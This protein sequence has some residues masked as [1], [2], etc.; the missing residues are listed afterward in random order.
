MSH[1]L[2]VKLISFRKTVIGKYETYIEARN[3]I[4]LAVAAHR[5]TYGD[6][7]SVGRS[8]NSASKYPYKIEITEMTSEAGLI[9]DT[10]YVE[11]YDNDLPY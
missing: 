2:A 3:R 1:Y 8:E 6:D 4:D 11:R 9:K 10:Y 7:N 5:G